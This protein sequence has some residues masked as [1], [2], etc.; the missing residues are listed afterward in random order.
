MDYLYKALK[1]EVGVVEAEAPLLAAVEKPR[2]QPVAPIL[3]ERA[4]APIAAGCGKPVAF[5]VNL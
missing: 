1:R 2:V 4:L 3:C 5:P